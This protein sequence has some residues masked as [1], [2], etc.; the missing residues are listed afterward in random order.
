MGFQVQMITSNHSTLKS[1]FL[2]AMA[3]LL[4]GCVHTEVWKINNFIERGSEKESRIISRINELYKG[5]CRLSN[6]E[7]YEK[8]SLLNGQ[9]V[10]LVVPN[11]GQAECQKAIPIAVCELIPTR[12]PNE[13]LDPYELC[14]R[15]K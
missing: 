9:Y 5:S 3:I 15:V 13:P 14:T 10:S 1:F 4:S 12:D 8:P 11:R 2:A 7:K 6:A